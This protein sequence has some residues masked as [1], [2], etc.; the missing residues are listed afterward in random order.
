MGTD[1]YGC[2]V[3]DPRGP[4]GDGGPGCLGMA[5]P[6]P[7][8]ADQPA[9]PLRRTHGRHH[10]GA[11]RGGVRP[12]PGVYRSAPRHGRAGSGARCGV[13]GPP[14]R[15]RAGPGGIGAD[16]PAGRPGPPLA[17]LYTRAFYP[18]LRL[19]GRTVPYGPASRPGPS[20]PPKFHWPD[21]PSWP[22]S[23]S[24]DYRH[25]HPAVV[26][27]LLER[28]HP[29]GRRLGRAGP[30]RSGGASL[31]GQPKDGPARPFLRPPLGHGGRPGGRAGR[32]AIP[33]SLRPVARI[34]D[35]P[36]PLGSLIRIRR[37]PAPGGV[38]GRWRADPPL[39]LW[40]GSGL[41]GRPRGPAEG[42][43]GRS[44]GPVPAGRGLAGASGDGPVV[45]A[46]APHRGPSGRAGRVLR[47]MG[48]TGGFPDG[49]RPL[50]R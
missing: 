31:L 37:R 46:P 5:T 33:L 2:R 35:P 27:A 24:L 36:G 32:R 16:P 30:E 41:P 7:A 23:P 18:P 6:P 1:G 14:L 12:G 48:G 28:V 19:D 26:R 34:A 29:P 22:K 40:S 44:P 17:H 21:D 4:G 25:P 42:D 50:E 3:G 11:G 47:R 8:A 45:P 15:G 38:A 20:P 13:H 9:G 43:A 10:S 49:E 39:G